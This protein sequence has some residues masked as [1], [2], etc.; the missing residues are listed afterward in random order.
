MMTLNKILR[1]FCS[2]TFV[3]AV[4]LMSSVTLFAQT[5]VDF[6]TND[7]SNVLYDFSEEF[8]VR[9]PFTPQLPIKT[10]EQ[11]PMAKVNNKVN[12]I[13][14]INQPSRRQETTDNRTSRDVRTQAPTW[15]I[16]GVIWNSDRPQAIING[17]VVDVGDEI[18]D[19]QIVAI[20]NDGIDIEFGNEKMTIKP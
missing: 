12:T 20:R 18:N 9:N 19:M 8:A 6:I 16:T 7:D 13:N 14:K 10:V 15:S 2:S 5:D 1:I 11:P 4:T 17:R 3:L